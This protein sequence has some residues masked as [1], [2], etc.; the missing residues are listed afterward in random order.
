MNRAVKCCTVCSGCASQVCGGAMADHP[1]AFYCAWVPQ[2]HDQSWN[3]ASCVWTGPPDPDL[4]EIP[5]LDLSQHTQPKN[6]WPSTWWGLLPVL[7]RR[8][9]QSPQAGSPTLGA[10]NS[11]VQMKFPSLLSSKNYSYFVLGKE[12]QFRA[13]TLQH[14]LIF[15]F[16]IH[17]ESEDT[18]SEASNHLKMA[19]HILPL[20]FFFTEH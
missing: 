7:P 1:Y 16:Q 19:H 8:L 4:A 5:T 2:K 15:D 13:L 12:P 17:T 6:G 9:T 3:S 20:I 18:D 14:R 11:G 10:T